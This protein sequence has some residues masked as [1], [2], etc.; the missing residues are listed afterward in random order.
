[1]VWQSSMSHRDYA[2]PPTLWPL[3]IPAG[4]QLPGREI[5]AA[6]H[7]PDG[8]GLMTSPVRSNKRN[9]PLWWAA[10]RICARGRQLSRLAFNRQVA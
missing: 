1:M 10:S 4:N 9:A 7:L 2:P 5:P 8:I 3:W 6:N